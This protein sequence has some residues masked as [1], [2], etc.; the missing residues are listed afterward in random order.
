MSIN[1]RNVVT[2]ASSEERERLFRLG[3]ALAGEKGDGRA[4]LVTGSGEEIE[5]PEAVYGILARVARELSEGRGVAV[6]PVEAELTTRQAAEILG[7]SRPHVV[8]LME[9]REIPFT[10]R[11]THRRARLEDVLAHKEKRDAGRI[12]ALDEM[13]REA[14]EIG[15]YD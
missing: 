4:Y 6:L 1:S 13:A 11:G 15:L 5:L 8:K 2:A 12:A 7:V 10:K 9:E 14:Q 3:R